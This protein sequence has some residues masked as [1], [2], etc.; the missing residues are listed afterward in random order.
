M[1]G[2]A[3]LLLLSKLAGPAAPPTTVFV[4]TTNAI[5]A[6][7]QRLVSRCR[8]LEFT[9]EGIE[10]DLPT[11][12]AGI[13]ASETPG[14]S[15]PDF[16]PQIA[17]AAGG[18]IRRAINSLETL[19]LSS[20]K[21]PGVVPHS[22][23]LTAVKA[24]ADC[25]PVEMFHPVSEVFPEVSPESFAALKLDIEEHGIRVPVV[26][27]EGMVL[28][29][30]SRWRAAQELGIECPTL[31]YDGSK[32]VS[33]VVSLNAI[34]RLNMSSGQRAI[35]AA[36]IANLGEGRP[37]KTPSID[38]VSE[39]KAARLLKVS[40]KS[41]ERAKKV[42]RANRP[43]L[44]DAVLSGRVSVSRAANIIS[45][46]ENGAPTSIDSS[47]TKPSPTNAFTRDQDPV[48]LWKQMML[49]EETRIMDRAPA[50]LLAQ[51][52]EQHSADVFRI[53]PALIAWLQ[54]FVG[55]RW[56]ICR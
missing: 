12:L 49:F 53:A 48:W 54:A 2:P 25:S 56:D 51:M 52:S 45:T 29:G 34:R 32:P 8:T 31:V 6:L 41:V 23:E 10:P 33:E 47:S 40:V 19:I 44:I 24:V 3:Q 22:A 35:A 30:R 36:K 38:P 21:L 1:S 46:G 15:A 17:Q 7:E 27:F 4:L 20:R 13:W 39:E 5:E 50:D 16:G 55:E 37:T 42:L 18:D 43:E 11:R 14:L 9:T 26:I 28:D